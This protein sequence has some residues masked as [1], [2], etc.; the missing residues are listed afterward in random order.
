M[1]KAR[2]CVTKDFTAEDLGF[3][4][5]VKEVE[6]GGRRM[7][8]IQQ[9]DGE[10]C[11]STIVIRGASENIMS[12]IRRACCD[13]IN[14]IR[15]MCRESDF[16]PGAGASEIELSRLIQDYGSKVSGLD[17]YAVKAYGEALEV[18]PRTLAAN[19]G[20]DFEDTIAKLYAAHSEGKSNIGIDILNKSTLDA[21]EENILDLLVTK[22]FA[23]RLATN[24]ALTILRVDHIIMSKPAGGPKKPQRQGHWDDDDDAW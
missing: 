2:M 4:K 18:V 13:G 8:R 20:M 7:T 15:A 22:K 23:M 10:S 11:V 14:T 16:C 5:S 21:V 17:Q 1:M 12:D 6:I 19:S 3:V 9:A 24:C